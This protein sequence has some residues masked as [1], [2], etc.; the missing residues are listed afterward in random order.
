MSKWQDIQSILVIIGFIIG[1]IQLFFLPTS[2]RIRYAIFGLLIAF[3]VLLFSLIPYVICIYLALLAL[4]FVLVSLLFYKIKDG[5]TLCKKKFRIRAARKLD[6]E[7]LREI[8]IERLN[9]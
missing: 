7:D 3:C 5:I 8:Y 4:I 1:V 9:K 2:R 6:I